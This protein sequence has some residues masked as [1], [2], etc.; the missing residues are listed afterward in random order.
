MGVHDGEKIK[1]FK[2]LD[3]YKQAFDAA[4]RIFEL[5]KQFPKEERYALV[6]QIRRS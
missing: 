5:T 4:M 6:D 3:V 2:N 1:S